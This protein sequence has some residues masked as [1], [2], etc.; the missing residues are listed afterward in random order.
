MNTQEQN[1]IIK[2]RINVNEIM[3]MTKDGRKT[4]IHCANGRDIET[5]HT[6]KSLMGA[7]HGITF[8]SINKGVV[9]AATYL[10]EVKNNCYT[11]SDGR[12]FNGRVRV[13]KTKKLQDERFLSSL[14]NTTTISD[15]SVLDNFPMA[16]CVIE[17]VFDE[18]GH[19]IDFIFRYCNAEMELLEGKKI[20]DM[21]G[22]SFYEIF[23]NGDKKWLITY[24]DV[25]LNGNNRIVEGYSPE[26]DS[27][28]KI[29]CSQPKPNFCACALVK[30]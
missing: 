19:G 25:A 6:I 15:F 4:V 3:Y 9:I 23:E 21:L 14:C 11:M 27:N 2:N 18:R 17:M 30:V 16:F 10:K 24:A 26:I 28:L 20:G 1:F 22:K 7:M 13:S 12:Q 5:F 29:Y 8:E